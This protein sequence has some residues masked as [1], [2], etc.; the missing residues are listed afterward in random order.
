MKY[1]Y[2]LCFISVFCN[3]LFAQEWTPVSP[4]PSEFFYSK[5]HMDDTGQGILVGSNGIITISDDFGETFRN[6]QSGTSQV[7]KYA[8]KIEEN[9]YIAVGEA[10]TIIRSTDGGESWEGIS[11]P[12]TVTLNEVYFV[13]ALEGFVIG[14]EGMV[15]HSVNGG[16]TWDII[17]LGTTVNL[18]GIKFIDEVTGYIWSDEHYAFFNTTDGGETWEE[19]ITEY[20]QS[21]VGLNFSD[22]QNGRVFLFQGSYKGLVLETSDGGITWDQVTDDS[23]GFTSMEFLDES[24]GFGYNVSHG[25]F[26]TRNGGNTW[27]EIGYRV[28]D[29]SIVG[30]NMVFTLGESG[31]LRSENLGITWISLS[32][33]VT[34]T[35]LNKVRFGEDSDVFVVGKG[36]SIY[37]SEDNGLS[38]E[39]LTINF[40]T[41]LPLV[42]IIGL[43]NDRVIAIGGGSRVFTS[44]NGGKNWETTVYDM[45]H[46]VTMNRIQNTIRILSLDG[47]ILQSDDLGL[48]WETKNSGLSNCQNIYFLNPSIG[49]I[50]SGSGF[51]RTNDG[52][53]TW[54]GIPIIS[55]PGN[56]CIQFVNENVG[57][58]LGFKLFK[59]VDGGLNW[60][61]VP[62][63]LPIYASPKS[64]HFRNELVGYCVGS[65]GR[66][67]KTLDG[68]ENWE[69]Q[70]S[71]TKDDLNSIVFNDEGIG[72][73]VGSKNGVILRI[74][75]GE[76]STNLNEEFYNISQIK[77]FPNPSSHEINISSENVSD[78]SVFRIFNLNGIQVSEMKGKLSGASI[79]IRNL[80]AGT[81]FI[82]HSNEEVMEKGV[83][84]KQ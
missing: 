26:K 59:T 66:I 7:L 2:L 21:I 41:S 69:Q 60:N 58:I 1:L 79:N 61:S 5:I 83:F 45:A 56:N 30:D 50:Q 77:I 4:Y 80:A 33:K 75:E 38:F 24:I 11:V 6:V 84:I 16:I 54:E 15:L 35:G 46:F 39:E 32:S 74:E 49:F 36:L 48:T 42:D 43:K 52:G 51:K 3:S 73:I 81:Y 10:G 78:N 9:V 27:E 22:A 28:H 55:T 72:M 82:L 57:Y 68:G 63:N 64:I 8:E 23:P 12:Y 13:N 31:I 53:E 71:Y 19:R 29:L 40:H 70:N 34:E 76:L 17:D 25:L 62:S 14:N 65:Q 37:K 18:T 47:E 20:T 67:F 44:I